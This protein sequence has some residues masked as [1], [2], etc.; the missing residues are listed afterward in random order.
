MLCKEGLSELQLLYFSPDLPLKFLLV[1]D[2][3]SALPGSQM[4]VVDAFFALC[5]FDVQLFVMLVHFSF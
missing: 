4:D 2:V 5:V 3:R 1:E